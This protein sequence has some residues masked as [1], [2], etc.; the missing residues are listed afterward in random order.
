METKGHS[1]VR[2]LIEGEVI[3][4]FWNLSVKFVVLANSFIIL[5]LLTVYDFGLYQLVIS[6]ITIASGLT[7]GGIDSIVEVS[8]SRFIGQLNMKSAKRLFL[9]YAGAKTVLGVILAISVFWGAHIIS[10]Y[11]SRD[12]GIYIK[13]ASIMILIESMQSAQDSFFRSKISFLNLSV[14][15]VNE[16]VKTLII[17]TLLITEQG[18]NIKS[19]LILH[20]IS[21]F[22]ALAFSSFYFMKAYSKLFTKSASESDGILW[23]LVK[24]HGL[25]VLLRNILSKLSSSTRLWLVRFFLNTEA[26]AIYSLARSALAFIITLFPIGTLGLLLPRELDDHKRLRHIFAR[27]LKYSS[28]LGILLGVC[29]FIFVPIAT[30][31][32]FPKYNEAIPLIKLMSVVFFLYGFYKIL[33]MM[34][35]ALQEQ[36]ILFVRSFDNTFLSIGLLALLLPIFGV[37]GAALEYVITYAVTTTLFYYWLVKTRPYLKIRAREVFAFNRDDVFFAVG[38]YKNV[39]VLFK[40]YLLKLKLYK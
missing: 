35:I 39:V 30:H 21:Q 15:L 23:P 34:I 4:G 12:I 38:L 29:F 27:M 37:W 8:I 13:I 2:N 28:F 11:Y 6:F 20:I 3:S 16:L 17:A 32:F 31:Y 5:T 22:C 24:A 26:V 1:L 36:R 18:L 25:W 7:S 9:E 19:V 33:R 14:P 40:D 10:N